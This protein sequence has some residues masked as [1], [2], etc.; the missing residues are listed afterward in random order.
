MSKSGKWGFGLPKGMVWQDLGITER[1]GSFLD[2]IRAADQNY[3]AGAY[4][5]GLPVEAAQ[6][7]PGKW[8]FGLP[9]GM[10]WQDLGITERLNPTG[11]LEA[12]KDEPLFQE[13]LANIIQKDTDSGLFDKKAVTGH[14][15]F[16]SDYKPPVVEGVTGTTGTTGETVEEEAAKAF[17]SQKAKDWL[18]NTANSPAAKAGFSDPQRWALQEKHREW[19]ANRGGNQENKI[20]S[21]LEQEMSW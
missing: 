18:A 14:T 10:V 13:N 15:I 2:A 16:P 20:M 7:T 21:P 17:L 1:V 19:L 8:G 11:A 6:Q 4:E 5:R 12:R 3:A 9:K